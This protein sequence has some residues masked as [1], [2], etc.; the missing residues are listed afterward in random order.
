MTTEVAACECA[1]E[2]LADHRVISG[3][4]GVE[5]PLDALELFFIACGDAIESL[6]VVLKSPT[7]LTEEKKLSEGLPQEQHARTKLSVSDMINVRVLT[8][9]R[10]RPHPC[11]SFS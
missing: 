5:D 6:V 9:Q 2:Y 11:I 3:G 10:G 7:A 1:L 8:C 4:N